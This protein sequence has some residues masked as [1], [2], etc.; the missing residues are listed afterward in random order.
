MASAGSAASAALA[1]L[2]WTGVTLFGGNDGLGLFGPAEPHLGGAAYEARF[3]FDTTIGFTPNLINGSE[4]VDGGALYGPTSISPLVSASITINGHTV[5]MAGD[6]EGFYFRQSGEG[7]SQISALAQRLI[8]G[9]PAPFGGELFQ[10]VSRLGNF[11][12]GKTLDLPGTF[13]FDASDSP[14]GEILVL[15]RDAAGN[16]SGP[17]TQIQLRPLRLR[18]TPE[19]STAGLGAALLALTVRLWRRTE[20][21]RRGR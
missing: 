12:G 20:R 1:K 17:T 2:T 7:A 21:N 19:P 4:Q 6:Y 3:I 11:Y 8:A 16:L 9:N 10:R 18:V 14:G 5:A 15:N 13:D